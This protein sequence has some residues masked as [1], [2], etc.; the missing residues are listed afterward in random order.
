MATDT[1]MTASGV[2]YPLW[3]LVLVAVLFCAGFAWAT[4]RCCFGR[5]TDAET[6]S[7]KEK[8]DIIDATRVT[9]VSESPSYTHASTPVSA[10][11]RV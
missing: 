8:A 9:C 7:S 2:A 3:F 5:S 10:I 4:L 6:V 11:D 1:S